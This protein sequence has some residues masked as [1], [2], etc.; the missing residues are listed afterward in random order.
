LSYH[1]YLEPKY[2]I[3]KQKDNSSLQV[4]AGRRFR[5]KKR[6]KEY[7]EKLNKAASKGESLRTTVP[8]SIVRQFGLTED[9]KLDWMIKAEGREHN[10]HQTN[11]EPDEVAQRIWKR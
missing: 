11:Q 9:D 6:A 10:S 8:L 3:A 2:L 4:V 1:R 5:L 7:A